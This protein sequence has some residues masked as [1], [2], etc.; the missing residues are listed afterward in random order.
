MAVAT[1]AKEKEKAVVTRD[2]RVVKSE[3]RRLNTLPTLTRS[4]T[5]VAMMVM[6]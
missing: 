6:M 3:P 2:E 5:H 1:P 4:S